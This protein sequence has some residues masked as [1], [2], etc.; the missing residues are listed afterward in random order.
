MLVV[1]RKA[2]ER[3]VI[4]GKITVEVLEVSGN[5]V[6]M[7]IQAPL[8][9]TILREELARGA[10]GHQRSGMNYHHN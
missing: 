1:T 9:L 10:R 2:G 4:D 3:I 8:E 5:R 7:G 6:R